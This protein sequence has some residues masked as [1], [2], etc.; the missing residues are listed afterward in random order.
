MLTVSEINW[1]KIDKNIIR[2]GVIPYTHH[3]GVTYFAF[4]VD[5]NN[6]SWVDFGGHKEVYD[7]DLLD[8]VIREYLEESYKVFGPLT[9][10]NLQPHFVMDGPESVEILVPVA[11]PF[12]NY[13]KNFNNLVTPDNEISTIIWLNRQQLLTILKDPLVFLNENVSYPMYFRVYDCLK[14]YQCYL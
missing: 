1:T 2:A 6:C 10:K 7:N 9:R 12:H 8:T 4:G 13:V 3:D 11:P 5:S 14:K